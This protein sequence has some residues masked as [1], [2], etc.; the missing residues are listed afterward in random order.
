M[1][2]FQILLYQTLP[3]ENYGE[4]YCHFNDNGYD[5]EHFDKPAAEEARTV[6]K[7]GQPVR[8]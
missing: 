4:N 3:A 5:V 8:E 2:G 6:Y 7:K 1:V